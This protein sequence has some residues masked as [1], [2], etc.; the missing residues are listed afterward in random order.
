MKER[1]N[2]INVGGRSS[3]KLIDDGVQWPMAAEASREGKC[4]GVV[5]RGQG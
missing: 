2:I 3:S 1:R 4:R 5:E